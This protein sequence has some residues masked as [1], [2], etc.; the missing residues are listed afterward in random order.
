MDSLDQD[1][2][3]NEPL[4]DD[5]ETSSPI[6]NE[7]LSVD[8]G[9]PVEGGIAPG[10]DEEGDGRAWYVVHC[11]S[12]YSTKCRHKLWQRMESMVMKD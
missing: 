3:P 6:E 2:Q 9:L 1:L 10:I 7:D 5:F 8:F 12:R 4:E 11:Y